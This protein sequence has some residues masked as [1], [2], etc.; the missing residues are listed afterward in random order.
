MIFRSTTK[1]F[2]EYNCLSLIILNNEYLCTTYGQGNA[3]LF[4]RK[5]RWR[6]NWEY[7]PANLSP[8]MVLHHP[9]TLRELYITALFPTTAVIKSC[10]ICRTFI[11]EQSI[12]CKTF[13]YT[14]IFKVPKEILHILGLRKCKKASYAV[15]QIGHKKLS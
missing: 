4:P 2:R 3:K 5:L 7:S 10:K 11:W 1:V 6:W 15:N 9:F 12:T 13:F 8:S 14:S